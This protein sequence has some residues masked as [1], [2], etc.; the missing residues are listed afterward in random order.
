MPEL[1]GE[2]VERNYFG[3]L[4]FFSE[5]RLVL[6]GD[7]PSKVLIVEVRLIDIVV[8]LIELICVLDVVFSKTDYIVFDLLVFLFPESPQTYSCK[9]SLL[10]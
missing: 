10:I 6:H 4:G 2:T 8:R 3:V 9:L 1:F 7:L 5:E